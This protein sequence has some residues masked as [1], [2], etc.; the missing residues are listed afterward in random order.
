MNAEQIM[1]AFMAAWSRV[2]LAGSAAMMAGNNGRHRRLA[3][4]LNPKPKH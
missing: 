2:D 4:K 1:L 3:A